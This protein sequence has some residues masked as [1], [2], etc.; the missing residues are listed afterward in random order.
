MPGLL[1]PVEYGGRINTVPNFCVDACK[2][3]TGS[4]PPSSVRGGGECVGELFV[5]YAG[6]SWGSQVLCAGVVHPPS[7]TTKVPLLLPVPENSAPPQLR[8]SQNFR[9][10]I[11]PKFPS[12]LSPASCQ[13]TF[14]RIFHPRWVYNKFALHVR[15]PLPVS[16]NS[17]QLALLPLL[18]SITLFTCYFGEENRCPF[19]KVIPINSS[20]PSPVDPTISHR[21]Q[22][23]PRS[24]IEIP[25]F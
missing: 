12:P 19:P 10:T 16:S 15:D 3:Q 4:T 14:I 20:T 6:C 7:P 22:T 17:D 13:L 21:C 18:L 5:E 25:T 23:S 11:P 8:S 2:T 1:G 9:R 24:T